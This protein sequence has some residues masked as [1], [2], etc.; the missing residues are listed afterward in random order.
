MDNFYIAR[1]TMPLTD[2]QAEDENLVRD[3][4]LLFRKDPELLPVAGSKQIRYVLLVFF[5]QSKCRPWRAP[6]PS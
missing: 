3:L 2:Y 6:H 4:I 5:W 1:L